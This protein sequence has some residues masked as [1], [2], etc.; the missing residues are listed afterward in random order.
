MRLAC[1]SPLPPST[2]GI[3]AYTAE[4][5]P[6]LRARVGVVDVFVDRP[7]QPGESGVWNAHDFVWKHR[8]EPY[9]VVVYQ[10]GN[11]ACHDYMWGYLFRYPGLVV[12]HDAQLHQ[13]RALQ[14]T[15]RHPPRPDDYV[16]E[17][18]ANH[19]DASPDLG[20]LV[21]AGL[22][23]G[24]YQRWPM[25]RL[26]VESAR[27]VA[28]HNDR[29]RAMLQAAYPDARVASIEMGVADPLDTPGGAA[30]VDEA[31]A[32]FRAAQGIPAD[33][34]VVAAFGGLTPEK[35]IE[36]LLRAVSAIR[37]RVPALHVLLAGAPAAYY[38]VMEDVAQLGLSGLVHVAGFVPD[39]ALPAAMRAADICCALRWPTNRETS[40]S[41]LRCLG[42]ARPTLITDLAHLTDVPALDP[43]TWRPATRYDSAPF[44]V[45]IDVLDEQHL[46]EVAL[47]RLA[48]DAELREELGR[49]ARAWWERHHRLEPMAEAYEALVTRAAG[50][51]APSPALPAHLLDDWSGRARDLATDLDLDLDWLR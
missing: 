47:V 17:F 49:A 22:D 31:A 16:A 28:V 36:P 40:A 6:G 20:R 2:S 23:G 12:L 7:P 4:L 27:L 45:A 13:A 38:D 3:A 33:A 48:E 32:R 37:D 5:L 24:L 14:L 15:R 44:A 41:W 50:L 25:V 19:P 42:A 39:H 43:R 11:A 10:L 18:L 1:F 9:D 8:R 34:V 46:L 26:V 29:V 21:A 30:A 51:A 35:R